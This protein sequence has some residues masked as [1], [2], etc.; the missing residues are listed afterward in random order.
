MIPRPG[1]ENTIEKCVAD[2]LECTLTVDFTQNQLEIKYDP[3]KYNG[4]AL[5]PQILFFYT[6]SDGS[7]QK[8]G[9]RLPSTTTKT[10]KF[11]WEYEPD[12]S[13][14]LTSE[15]TWTLKLDNT[16][17]ITVVSPSDVSFTYTVTEL[18]GDV[19]AAKIG[20]DYF[21]TSVASCYRVY[22]PDQMNNIGEYIMCSGC[23][24]VI[25]SIV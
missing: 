10:V 6:D 15:S 17:Q 14:E 11:R 9:V 19:S 21:D 7:S 20:F 24:N 3:T 13:E 5:N 2:N 18:S 1:C 22:N 25:L 16:G 8:W 23:D 4:G 12:V